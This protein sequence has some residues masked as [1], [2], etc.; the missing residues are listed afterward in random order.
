VVTLVEQPLAFVT[1]YVM[2]AVPPVMPVTLPLASTVATAV[3]LEDHVPPVVTSAR[4]VVDPA[5]T[6]VV[7]VMG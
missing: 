1:V 2:V 7:P 3:L 5:Q 6:V 4:G